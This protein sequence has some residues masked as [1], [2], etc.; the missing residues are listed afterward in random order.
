MNLKFVVSVLII[1]VGSAANA[2]AQV[3]IDAS[4]I[5]C[6]QFVHSKVASVRSVAIWLSGYYGGKQGNPVIDTN[7]LEEKSD[8]LENFCQQPKNLKLPV[9]QA[10]EQIFGKK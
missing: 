3:T 6:E 8:K 1:V 9:M 10:V 7:A 2:H 4:K 5:T